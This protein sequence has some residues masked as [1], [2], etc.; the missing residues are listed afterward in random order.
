MMIVKDD[1]MGKNPL[2]S[3]PSEAHPPS[4]LF[5]LQCG[6]L[7]K[8]LQQKIMRDFVRRCEQRIILGSYG[9]KI[10]RCKICHAFKLLSESFWKFSFT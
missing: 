7:R 2:I 1:C 4:M 8:G 9:V 5:Q 3:L 6:F 10:T